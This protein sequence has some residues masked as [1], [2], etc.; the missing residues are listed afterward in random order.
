MVSTMQ[1]LR[2]GREVLLAT[3]DVFLNEPVIDWVE[4]TGDRQTTTKRENMCTASPQK[5]ARGLVVGK[6]SEGV[7]SALNSGTI[8]VSCAVEKVR[9]KSIKAA[10]E[11]GSFAR[12]YD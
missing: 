11:I 5:E 2:D 10:F 9:W 7:V 6:C 1:A 8:T 3:M 4:T 12:F